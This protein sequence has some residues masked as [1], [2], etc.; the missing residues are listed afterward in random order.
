MIPITLTIIAATW[1]GLWAEH[2]WP[3]RAGTG[4]RRA[5]TGVLYS[6]LP[7]VVFLNL[8]RAELDGDFAVGVVLAWLAVLSSALVVYLIGSRVL[9]LP[10]SEVGA[11]MC[12]VLVANTGYL[13]YPLIG[14]TLGFDRI[15]EAVVYDV[16]VSISSLLVAAFAVGAAF[17]TR[18]GEGARARARAFFTRNVPLYAAALALVAPD[19]LAPDL[20]IDISRVIIVC[21]LPLGFFAVGAVLAEDEEKGEVRL[22][23][24]LTKPIV[25]AGLAKVVML[26][27]LLFLLA[28]PLIELP[29]TFLVLAAMPSGLNSMIVAHAYGLDLKIIAGALVWTTGVV[30]PMALVASLL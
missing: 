14:A 1:A 9:R 28:A 16:L 18:A 17:G 26:P 24:T 3:G 23:P 11:M 27:S 5:L 29:T 7:L 13:G 25:T 22:P 8:V 19:W 10:R 30:V 15:G 12:C 2:R 6:A 20:A 21:L 4:S